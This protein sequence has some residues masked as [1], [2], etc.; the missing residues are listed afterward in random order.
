MENHN[1]SQSPPIQGQVP[2]QMRI[3]IEILPDPDMPEPELSPSQVVGDPSSD[4]FLGL[5]Y[6]VDVEAL[7]E[8]AKVKNFMI[9]GLGFSVEKPECTSNFRDFFQILK[10]MNWEKRNFR[11]T[12]MMKEQ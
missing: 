11:Y 7:Q 1:S 5:F 10:G 2:N 3:G 4:T 8:W 6:R 9:G 12:T